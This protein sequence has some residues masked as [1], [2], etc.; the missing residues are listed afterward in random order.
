MRRNR[1]ADQ[2]LFVIVLKGSQ[3]FVKSLEKNLKNNSE[4]VI[5]DI[6]V[7]LQALLEKYDIKFPKK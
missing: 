5:K 3:L 6:I 4:L 7:G 2:Y 1:L